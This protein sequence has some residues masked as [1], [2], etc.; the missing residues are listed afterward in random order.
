MKRK[1]KKIPLIIVN[2]PTAT[3]K[4]QLAVS[5]ALALNGEVI[6]ADS[7]QVY[8]YLNIGTAKPTIEQRKDVKHHLIDILNPD[9]E[10]NAALFA[11]Q[12]RSIIADLLKRKKIFCC[13]WNGIIY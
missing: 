12:S 5:L 3:G 2:S 8:R 10:Y 4:T 9:E 1:I 6:S 11:E 7:L 13:R